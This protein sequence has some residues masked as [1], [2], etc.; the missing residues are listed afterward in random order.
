V[1]RGLTRADRVRGVSRVQPP[2]GT[3]EHHLITVCLNARETLA[4]CSRS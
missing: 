4:R 2:G 1:S 3:P